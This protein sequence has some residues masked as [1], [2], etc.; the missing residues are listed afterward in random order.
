MA[1]N[2]ENSSTGNCI[3]LCLPS[4]CVTDGNPDRGNGVRFSTASST[5]IGSK[6][7]KTIESRLSKFLNLFASNHLSTKSRILPPLLDLC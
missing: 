3:N 1:P 6:N 5:R 2:S 4:S 7:F